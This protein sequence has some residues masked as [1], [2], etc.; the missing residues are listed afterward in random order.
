MGVRNLPYLAFD[1]YAEVRRVDVDVDERA[2]QVPRYRNIQDHVARPGLLVPPK[3][4]TALVF[5]F[6]LAFSRLFLLPSNLCDCL[7]LLFLCVSMPRLVDVVSVL[8]LF[9]LLRKLTIN[10]V[11]AICHFNP[12]IVDR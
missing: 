8:F 12:K 4:P 7:Q 5:L 3:F 11:L 10:L 1:D 9:L 6:N 2:V